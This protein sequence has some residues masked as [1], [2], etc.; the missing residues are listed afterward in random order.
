MVWK[1]IHS[2]L[3]GS[4]THCECVYA[5]MRFHWVTYSG[6]VYILGNG[7]VH[8][9]GRPGIPGS[10]KGPWSCMGRWVKDTAPGAASCHPKRSSLRASWLPASGLPFWRNFCD[11]FMLLCKPVEIMTRLG[12][13]L[14][15]CDVSN[16]KFICDGYTEV[17][18]GF[19]CFWQFYVPF[20]WFKE[21][22]TLTCGFKKYL[23]LGNVF[24]V[25]FQNELHAVF[26]PRI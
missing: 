8:W 17:F 3:G 12:K 26:N 15:K 11:I 20:G 19:S 13:L 23:C 10:L 9:K 22:F 16:V 24:I 7:K 18:E 5:F 21:V 1:E 25:H 4:R 14:N 2:F 6:F